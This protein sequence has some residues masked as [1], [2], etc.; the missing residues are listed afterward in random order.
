MRLAHLVGL[1][2]IAT[3]GGTAEAW[4]CKPFGPG[5]DLPA[6]AVFWPEPPAISELKPG[7]SV[8]RVA[9]KRIATDHDPQEI[10]YTRSPTQRDQ[11][12]VIITCF[13]SKIYKLVD[14][15]AG[16]SPGPNG[17]L[18]WGLH[19]HIDPADPILVGHLIPLK[20]TNRNGSAAAADSPAH[21]L[22]PRGPPG[23]WVPPLLQG[24][25]PQ[26]PTFPIPEIRL[27]VP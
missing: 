7:E 9:F 4:A 22:R 24:P 13:G 19:A 1:C 8:L 15:L 26:L 17:V 23:L 2:L 5:F 25:A 12:I 14:V 20:T 10:D 16:D 27:N 11:D 3:L 6:P 18:V 21:L